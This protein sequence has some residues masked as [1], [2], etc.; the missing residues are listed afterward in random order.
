MQNK[1]HIGHKGY[2]RTKNE[3]TKRRELILSL[4]NNGLRPAE[5]ANALGYKSTSTVYRV[6]ANARV[7]QKT[8]RSVLLPFL[9]N[10]EEMI[11]SGISYSEISKKYG[12]DKKT[13]RMFCQSHGIVLSNEQKEANRITSS[14]VYSDEQIAGIVN[15]KWPAFE[16]VSG[17]TNNHSKFVI[18]CL[19]CGSEKR[20][21][22]HSS[23]V[24]D[25][26][27]A[28]RRNES[29]AAREAKKLAL[30]LESEKQKEEKRKVAELAKK[31]KVHPCCVCG[32]ATNRPKFCSDVCANKM[33]NKAKEIKRRIRISNALVDNDISIQGLYKR[34]KGICH[35][36]GL[37]CNWN[38][39]KVRNEAVICGDWYPSIDHVVPL[40]KG[41]AHAW[42][43]VM[44]A[45]RR[46]NYIKSDGDAV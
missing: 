46:C 36:C 38:D 37:V 29:A 20:V 5:I 41:G 7:F 12:V 44:L 17:Y 31:K 33:R 13:V 1:Q 40:S 21:V 16:Y 4:H 14:G 24:C 19:C 9:A 22:L 25:N 26:C 23:P 27:E 6:L 42:R 35:I 8:E 45:H 11:S 30:K 39:Y 18:R 15:K 28:V 32:Q 10:V 3:L 43:N 2:G 34:D